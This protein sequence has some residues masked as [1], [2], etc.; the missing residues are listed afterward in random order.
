[1][2]APVRQG[3]ERA[4]AAIRRPAKPFATGRGLHPRDSPRL[5]VDGMDAP[6]SGSCR[7]FHAVSC[8]TSM[9]FWILHTL[10][11]RS[12]ATKAQD[13]VSP[14]G[15]GAHRSVSRGVPFSAVCGGRG[16][17]LVP[18]IAAL[19][20]RHVSMPARA[21]SHLGAL[22]LQSVP[23]LIIRSDESTRVGDSR[24]FLQHYAPTATG[25]ARD[26]ADVVH[27]WTPNAFVF[28][29]HQVT[30]TLVVMPDRSLATYRST[31]VVDHLARAGVGRLEAEA[32]VALPTLDDLTVRGLTPPSARHDCLSCATFLVFLESPTGLECDFD[33]ATRLLCRWLGRGRRPKTPQELHAPIDEWKRRLELHQERSLDGGDGPVRTRSCFKLIALSVDTSY[34]GTRHFCVPRFPYVA[35]RLFKA[36]F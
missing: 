20:R 30:L 15:A 17:R 23:Q 3:L 1:M 11:A 36:V 7:I 25:L 26:A 9:H 10:H 33:S 5:Q 12:R 21:A 16:A 6:L 4:L 31:A 22:L 14:R 27:T 34:E 32:D 28:F 24:L 29:A 19:L 2:A 8:S 35:R 18:A 13:V